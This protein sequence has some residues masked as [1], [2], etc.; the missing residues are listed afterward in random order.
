MKKGTAL[1]S[2]LFV[3]VI[4]LA[5]VS[6]M[7]SIA[8][9]DSRGSSHI[10]DVES[11]IQCAEAGL[12]HAIAVVSRGNPSLDQDT[13][14]YEDGFL[15]GVKSDP[16][17][18][19]DGGGYWVDARD[20]GNDAWVIESVGRQEGV[21]P[22]TRV[23]RARISPSFT[24]TI[25]QYGAFG[26]DYLSFIQGSHSDS[27]DSRDGP[28]S[29]ATKRYN[30]H[31]GTNGL[32]CEL[33]EASHIHGNAYAGPGGLVTG[34]SKVT[35]TVG[36]LQEK[37]DLPETAFPDYT[38]WGPR[39]SGGNSSLPPGDYYYDSMSVNKKIT[40][41]GPSRIVVGGD[42]I[43]KGGSRITVDASGGPVSIYVK[44]SFTASHGSKHGD[45]LP[46]DLSVVVSDDGNGD[47][48]IDS[49]GDW[50]G[51]IYAPSRAVEFDGGSKFFGALIGRTVLGSHGSHVHYDE[52]LGQT[53]EGTKRMHY[54]EASSVSTAC[55]Q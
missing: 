17:R 31:V 27:Y 47:V 48:V 28:Y 2:V 55:P 42:F 12:A 39:G 14:E 10:A 1:I 11:A 29:G 25:W 54:P 13:V 9:T 24:P 34:G 20:L 40:L 49:G 15:L 45:H 7:S 32:L 35:G 18:F 4:G 37:M 5:L 3:M 30:G 52:S 8:I 23:V 46:K 19:G 26:A 50:R 44:G 33:T 53:N 43:A 16:V 22:V 6:M 51:T 36:N 41:R 21:S 38:G